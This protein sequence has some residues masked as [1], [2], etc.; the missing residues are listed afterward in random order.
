[1]A[2]ADANA[3]EDAAL[4]ALRG[5]EGAGDAGAVE[6]RAGA[7]GGLTP[8]QLEISVVGRRTI[9]SACQ[10]GGRHD[11]LIQRGGDHP[12]FGGEPIIWVASGSGMD[13]ALFRELAAAVVE[14]SG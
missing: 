3:L 9:S 2:D 6:W 1:M 4:Y 13:E 8:G 5:A 7:V 11:C 14:V 12:H 10:G